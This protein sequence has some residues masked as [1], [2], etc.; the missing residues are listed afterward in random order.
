[1]RSSHADSASHCRKINVEL[2]DGRQATN[3]GFQIGETC[4]EVR[5]NFIAAC[6]QAN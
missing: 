5:G 4:C 1:V 6:R 3:S 2:R